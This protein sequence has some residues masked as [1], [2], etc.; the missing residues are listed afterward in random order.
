MRE[1]PTRRG[2]PLVRPNL[3]D[4]LLQAIDPERAARRVRARL[5]YDVMTSSGAYKGASRSRRIS[6]GWRTTGGSADA[7]SLNDLQDLRERSRDLVRNAPIATGALSTQVAK[8]VGT[9]L[10]LQARPAYE[11]LGW[12]EEQAEAWKAGVE[13]EWAMW[14]ESKDCDI[15]RRQNFYELQALAFRSTLESGDV[16]ALLKEVADR[17]PYALVVQLVEADRLSNK[18]NA[19]DTATLAGGVEMDANGAP[20]AYHVRRQHPGAVHA[21]RGEWDEIPAYGANSG[22]RNVLHLFERRRPD[23]TR[24]V[25]YLA[26]VIEPLKQLSDYSEYELEAAALSAVFTVFV[27]STGGSGLSPLESAT[28][29]DQPASDTPAASWDGKLGSGLAVELA[30][31]QKVSTPTPGRPN[32]GFDN[33]FLAIVREIGVALDLPYEVLIK[34]FQSS[35]SAARAALLDAWSFFKV[36]REWLAA[37]FCQPVYEEWFADAVAMGRVRAPGFFRDPLLRWAYTRAW[38]VGDGPGAIDPVKEAQAATM[39]IDGNLSTL[40]SESMALDGS[41][42]RE[43]LRQRGREQREIATQGLRQEP[44]TPAGTLAPDGDPGAPDRQDDE[45][46]RNNE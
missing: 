43:N 3:L 34:H 26:P 24:G 29:A 39:R 22:R 42:W 12:T 17:R 16:L 32:A 20:V 33:F 14:S 45:E 19:P 27:E 7:D 1:V 18:N 35:Y 21:V 40:E 4:R 2:Q 5:Q 30:P 23:Q 36:R 41:N 44:V 10:S 11:L 28:S 38:W 46:R 8:V 37:N 15:S 9:G 6:T 13:A 25:P 31:G